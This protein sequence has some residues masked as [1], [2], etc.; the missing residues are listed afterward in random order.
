MT[1]PIRLAAA[2]LACAGLLVS[3]SSSAQVNFIKD[4]Y[5]ISM[6]DSIGAGEGALPVTHGFAYQLYEQGVFGRTQ[7]LDFGNIAIRAATAEDV[8]AF[9]VPQALC[10]QPPRIAAPP[11]VITLTAGAGDFLVYLAINGVPPNPAVTIPQVADTIAARVEDVIR[12]LVFGLPALP[13]SCA[14]GIPGITVLVSNYFGFNHPDPAVDQ[15]FDLALQ[16]FSASLAGRVAQIRTDIGAAGMTA[17]VG[18]VD[19]FSAMD[20]RHGLLLIERR[21][22]FTGGFDFELHPTS[23]GHSV[24]ADEF[25]RVWKALQ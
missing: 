24:I 9:Q 19:T 1:A 25:A 20:G 13:P 4:G 16:S 22:G 14:G 23:A 6:G 2:S 17:R 3:G 18:F 5:Y 12:A 7:T 8:L 15:L 21:D 11:S 10:I